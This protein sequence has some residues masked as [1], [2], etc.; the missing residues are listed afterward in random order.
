MQSDDLTVYIALAISLVILFQ[1][2]GKASSGNSPVASMVRKL[3]LVIAGMLIAVGVWYTHIRALDDNLSAFDA[4]SVALDIVFAHLVLTLPILVGLFYITRLIAPWLLAL[5]VLALSPVLIVLWIL[6]KIVCKSN[7]ENYELVD[8][9]LFPFIDPLLPFHRH[10]REFVQALL[11]ILAFLGTGW[12]MALLFIETMDLQ[13][14]LLGAF[15]SSLGWNY[16]TTFRFTI[17][18][19]HI[20]GVIQVVSGNEA[21][22]T[23]VSFATLAVSVVLGSAALIKAVK[24]IG[25]AV[26]SGKETT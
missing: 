8:I 6:A 25:E 10:I 15:D 1:I 14:F 3:A 20:K 7:K 26:K 9:L 2:R 23:I 12:L 24:D 13:L 21:V 17:L 22:S 4:W 16:P 18:F 11:A 19:E 5:L